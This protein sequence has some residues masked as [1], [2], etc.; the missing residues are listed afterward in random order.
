MTELFANLHEM[1]IYS[2]PIIYLL[3]LAGFMVGFINTITGSVTVMDQFHIL[4]LQKKAISLA[5]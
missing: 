4:G 1:D 5:V 2:F 3:L